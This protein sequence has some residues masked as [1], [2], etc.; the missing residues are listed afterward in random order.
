MTQR[1]CISMSEQDV[2]FC[3][4]RHLSPSQLIKERIEQ[5]RENASD[6]LKLAVKEMRREI[7]NDRRKIETFSRL[8]DNFRKT[9]ERELGDEEYSKIF[10]KVPI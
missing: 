3:W 8:L 10:E 2:K 1:K 7:E 5:I 9:F 4:E 6:S